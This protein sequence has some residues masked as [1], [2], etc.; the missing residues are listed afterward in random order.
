[1]KPEL[2]CIDLVDP[3]VELGGELVQ[4]LRNVLRTGTYIGGPLVDV[5]EQD[6]AQFCEV[7]HCVALRSGTDALR[8]TLKGVGVQQGESV[9]T[10]ANAPVAPIES[11]LEA[12]AFPE[13]V[14]I[15]ERTC[16][17]DPVS[18]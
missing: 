1:M 5:F 10:V 17:I 2:P 13:L 3:E 7:K 14:D 4:I 12:G 18:L 15:D 9:I 16:S 6:F 8:L 11:I